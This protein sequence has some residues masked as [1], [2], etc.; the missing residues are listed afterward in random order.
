MSIASIGQITPDSLIGTY[1]G[2][3]WFKWEED[4]NWTIFD[5]SVGITQI[6]GC[7]LWSVVNNLSMGGIYLAGNPFYET[8]YD[9]CLG[10]SSNDF[11]RFHS[12]DSLT[13]VYRYISPPPPNYHPLSVLFY[14][15]KVSD[16][17][18]VSVEKIST[19]ELP[20]KNYPNPFTTTTT[21]EFELQKMYT[22]HFKVYNVM[23]EVV[24][25]KENHFD[26]GPHHI[27]WS[28][29]SLPAGLYFGVL[30]FNDNV[31]VVKL[32]KQ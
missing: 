26:P 3:R 13:I 16:S 23:G 22:V 20:L 14:G 30:K 19:N 1:A 17:I 12:T 2:E 32:L 21:I 5:D 11:H 18:L 10:N 7:R 15:K 9:F 31:E 24:Y 29:G 4:T 28:P 27:S 8:E 6:E 25:Q